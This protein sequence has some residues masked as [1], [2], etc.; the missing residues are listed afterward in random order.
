MSSL[1]GCHPQLTQPWHRDH[2]STP[3]IER[4]A[5]L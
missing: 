4:S 5:G 3:T 2:A 1:A